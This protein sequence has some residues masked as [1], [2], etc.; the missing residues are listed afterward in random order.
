[1]IKLA[2]SEYLDLDNKLQLENKINA[3]P[4][5]IRLALSENISLFSE[6]FKF[7]VREITTSDVVNVIESRRPRAVTLVETLNKQLDKA[8]K[9]SNK[10]D[11]E[12][13][14]KQFEKLKLVPESQT[15]ADAKLT[16]IKERVGSRKIKA[17]DVTIGGVKVPDPQDK[18]DDID[19]APKPKKDVSKTVKSFKNRSVVSSRRNI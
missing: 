1:M 10:N 7:I 12:S 11:I 13:A 2:F 17:H 9:D 16:E 3:T 8:I 14:L 18:Q 19:V 15:L 4:D 5:A 6:E